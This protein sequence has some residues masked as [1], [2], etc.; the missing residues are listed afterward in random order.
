MLCFLETPVLRFA[1]LP[2]YRP[3]V[4]DFINCGLKCLCVPYFREYV[5]IFV[6]NATVLQFLI[7]HVK[8]FLA[9]P[10]WIRQ[11]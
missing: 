8:V 10:C 4:C 3:I 6:E 1:I 7:R 9:F 11:Y 2:Y 5:Y